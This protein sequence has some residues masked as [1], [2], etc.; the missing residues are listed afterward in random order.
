MLAHYA[1]SREAPMS[2][3]LVELTD[4][5]PAISREAHESFSPPFGSKDGA[6]G[7]N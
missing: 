7:V 4:V 6:F 1:Q 2:S 5:C 3:L